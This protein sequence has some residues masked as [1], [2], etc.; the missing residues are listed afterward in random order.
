MINDK[1]KLIKQHDKEGKIKLMI[2]GLGSVGNYLL[3]YLF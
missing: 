3:E 2:I 1:L